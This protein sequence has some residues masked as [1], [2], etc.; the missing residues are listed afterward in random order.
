[1]QGGDIRGTSDPSPTRR[2]PLVC[3][4]AIVTTLHSPV[5]AEMFRFRFLPGCAAR[6]RKIL[7]RRGGSDLRL[8]KVRV[9][10]ID[11][12]R[13]RRDIA[14]VNSGGNYHSAFLE[15]TQRLRHERANRRED[16]GSVEGFRRHFVGTA[17]PG[18]TKPLREFL[19][20]GIARTGESE[21]LASFKP[22][23]LTNDMGSG[24]ESVQA[25]PFWV[26]AF[27]QRAKADQPGA[28]QRRGCDVFE[29]VGNGKT[30]ARV[31]HNKFSV[32][33]V[34]VVAG[35]TGTVA[36]IFATGPAELAFT[37]RPA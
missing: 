26:A 22:R 28:Q 4:Y 8:N 19:R 30:K 33:A 2:R 24:A 17:G 16:D 12:D 36:K 10:P 9:R 29:S 15:V 11:R 14:H 3:R 23:D 21:N 32:T 18:C 37:A 6:F 20:F 35:K 25:E 1:M 7:R 34:N 5:P 27:A 13:E 31:G